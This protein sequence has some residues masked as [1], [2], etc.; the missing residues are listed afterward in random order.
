MMAP[1]VERDVGGPSEAECCAVIGE[2]SPTRGHEFVDAK[3]RT[4]FIGADGI[5]GARFCV[6]RPLRDAPK[7]SPVD[8]LRLERLDERARAK[9]WYSHVD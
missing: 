6:R 8:A 3:L 7:P 2:A 4:N 1:M 9:S 5:A